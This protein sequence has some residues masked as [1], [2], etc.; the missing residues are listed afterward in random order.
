MNT[1]VAA[2]RTAMFR[3]KHF[4]DAIER[5]PSSRLARVGYQRLLLSESLLD[6]EI[7]VFVGS[8]LVNI[9]S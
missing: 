5:S 7:I 8:S 2:T 4:D 1:R 3:S 6:E 9:L